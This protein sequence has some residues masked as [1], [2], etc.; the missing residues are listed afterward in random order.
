MLNIL[1]SSLL[2]I[3]PPTTT[4]VW[5]VFRKFLPREEQKVLPK[6]KSNYVYYKLQSIPITARGTR[7]PQ[8]MG[9]GSPNHQCFLRKLHVCLRKAGRKQGRKTPEHD[10]S[11]FSILCNTPHHINTHRD[12]H[13]PIFRAWRL[14]STPGNPCKKQNAE[15]IV[16]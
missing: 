10:T 16:D 14:H 7:I 5:L 11:Y 8:T 13:Y 1:R 15:G 6:I 9:I 3:S 12:V 2:L 4:S